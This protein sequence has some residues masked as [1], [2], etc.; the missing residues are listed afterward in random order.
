MLDSTRRLLG[1]FLAISRGPR[2]LNFGYRPGGQVVA[3]KLV[4]STG[5]VSTPSGRHI[6]GLGSA[7]RSTG[8]LGP[9]SGA[10]S[11]AAPP[12]SSPMRL[13]HRGP[14]PARLP[15]CGIPPGSSK[16]K[17]VRKRRK[18]ENRRI[19]KDRRTWATWEEE[20][21]YLIFNLF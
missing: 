5:E 17:G 6:G 18:R 21:C 7:G 2:D 3:W 4:E 13:L 11:P 10:A 16:G 8:E 15:T 20:G 1:K 14:G 12:A 9:A 19:W